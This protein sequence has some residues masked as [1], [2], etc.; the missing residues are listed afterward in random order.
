MTFKKLEQNQCSNDTTNSYK[1]M[2]DRVQEM[3]ENAVCLIMNR[4]GQTKLNENIAYIPELGVG[5]MK[6]QQQQKQQ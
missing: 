2:I 6:M 1:K 5:F 3:S 4:T